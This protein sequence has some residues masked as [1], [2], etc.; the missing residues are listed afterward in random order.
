MMA[1]DNDRMIRYLTHPQ[2]I[3]DPDKDVQ[4]WSLND[5][6][7]ARIAALAMSNVLQGVS[8][9]FSSNE[10][11]A[12]EAAT[13]LANAAG[14]SVQ[15]V[16]EMHENDRSATGFLPPD[17]FEQAAD[18]FFAHPN[19]SFRGWETSA[20]AQRRIVTAVTQCLA[21]DHGGDVLIVG[22]GA[23]GTL[24]FCHLSGLP[25]DRQ[26]DQGPGGGGNY[27]DFYDMDNTPL[28]GWRPLEH[29]TSQ[30]RGKT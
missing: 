12:I 29:L 3:M 1:C 9:I 28:H 26:Y 30:N 21:P 8:A 15:I 2:V 18:Q 6:G 16:Q 20:D 10:T 22:H 24:L 23:V 4:Q 19:D 11:K 27:F 13:P 5:V 25:I 14:L 7:H 17:E